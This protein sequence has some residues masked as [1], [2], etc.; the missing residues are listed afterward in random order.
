[1]VA[2]VQAEYTA[3]TSKAAAAPKDERVVVA[4]GI[5]HSQG[6]TRKAAPRSTGIARPRPE[7]RAESRRRRIAKIRMPHPMP[8]IIHAAVDA[9]TCVSSAER[10]RQN[11]NA[12]LARQCKTPNPD[13]IKEA[14]VALHRRS[15]AIAT[16]GR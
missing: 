9:N 6:P 5:N 15:R 3:Q 2:T 8:T 7:L 12:T 4:T 13:A 16:S 1:M 10:A 11:T 14:R